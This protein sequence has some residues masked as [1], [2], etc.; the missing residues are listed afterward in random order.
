VALEA[1]LVRGTRAEGRMEER[2]AQGMG[3]PPV[4]SG[5]RVRDACPFHVKRQIDRA[6]LYPSA[7][8]SKDDPRCEVKRE[9]KE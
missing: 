1:A 7:D 4:S 9:I 8:I 3:Y 2:I 6:Y 5:Q